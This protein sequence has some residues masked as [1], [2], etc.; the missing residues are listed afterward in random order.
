MGQGYDQRLKTRENLRDFKQ[1]ID[2]AKTIDSLLFLLDIMYTQN[3]INS[4]FNHRPGLL[5]TC[6][7]RLFRVASSESTNQLILSETNSS[8]IQNL[9]Q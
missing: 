9:K 1:F 3:I 4:Y 7:R 6:Q 8:L 2:L 5:F